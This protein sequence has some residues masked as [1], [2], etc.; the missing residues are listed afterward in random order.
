[1]IEEHREMLRSNELKVSLSYVDDPDA[2]SQVT[3][4]VHRHKNNSKFSIVF[5]ISKSK[6]ILTHTLDEMNQKIQHMK[7][8]SKSYLR[9]IKEPHLKML[10]DDSE[11]YENSIDL[12]TCSYHGRQYTEGEQWVDVND[13]CET[14]TCQRG[15]VVCES[16]VCFALNCTQG[17]AP[18]M[19]GRCCPVCRE[20]TQLSSSLTSSS[21]ASSSSSSPKTCDF[22]GRK[23][24]SGE[25]WNPFLPPNGFNRCIT[26]MCGPNGYPT[27]ENVKCPPLSCPLYDR[28][29]DGCCHRCSSRS[30]SPL[31]TSH[32]PQYDQ[33]NTDP[34]AEQ[35][36][37]ER[38]LLNGGGCRSGGQVYAN[39]KEWHIPLGSF[40]TSRCTS[41]KC[42]NGKR[43]CFNRQC[44][45]QSSCRNLV[46][47]SSECCPVCLDDQPVSTSHR[48]SAKKN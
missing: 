21:F 39:G 17:V 45:V 42:K 23:F 20:Q 10:N 5:I 36:L 34:I 19:A 2:E 37:R 18:P 35:Q 29:V 33:A 31:Y 3:G 38:D 9:A 28:V 26:C 8:H 43:T 15:R 16:E 25:K 6:P 24:Q 46:T 27:C 14:C 47:R 7:R 32:L 41:C 4:I 40:G 22:M 30:S 48:R 1:M 11:S 44:P 13:P 12:K